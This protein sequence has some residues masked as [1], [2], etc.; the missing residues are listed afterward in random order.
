MNKL[1]GEKLL[2]IWWFFCLALVLVGVIFGVVLFYGGEY[3]IRSQEAGALYGNF[4]SCFVKDNAFL[5]S[6]VLDK[7]FDIF[8][9]CKIN[10]ELF[11]KEGSKFFF[12]VGVYDES[13]VLIV[14]EILMGDYS[15]EKNCAN[16]EG[17]DAEAFPKCSA[18]TE[19]FFYV[20]DN[21]IKKGYLSIL[22]ASNSRGG[23]FKNGN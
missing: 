15:L 21:M 17:I 14:D 3:D 11:K 4:F 9:E 2:S 19:F 10:S 18:G 22:T 1:G 13:S 6:N 12:K 7:D 5:D 20:E 16:L 8:K 23:T